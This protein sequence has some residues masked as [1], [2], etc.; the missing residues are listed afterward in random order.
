[1][2]VCCVILAPAWGLWSGTSLW[3]ASRTIEINFTSMTETEAEGEIH[4][5]ET[6][7]LTEHEALL[8]LKRAGDPALVDSLMDVWE[9]QKLLVAQELT[10]R[11]ISTTFTNGRYELNWRASFFNLPSAIGPVTGLSLIS[12]NNRT[13]EYK[14]AA[15]I[16]LPQRSPGTRAGSSLGAFDF[17]L[18][19]HFPGTV[20]R[21]ITGPG[22][23]DHTGE[24]VS[25]KTDLGD[26]RTKTIPV[27]ATV[28][29]GR[30]SEQRY[31]L[32]LMVTLTVLVAVIMLGILRRGAGNSKLIPNSRPPTSSRGVHI[33]SGKGD[34]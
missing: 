10:V 27:A 6:C 1:M 31:W 19:V 18:R 30:A 8:A 13:E 28:I 32:I 15:S 16:G 17:T 5:S 24:T 14:F 20:N 3:A 7:D 4:G 22:Q 2:T 33:L 21:E 25:W 29:P 23:I 12:T 9:T 11:E 26:L 34:R